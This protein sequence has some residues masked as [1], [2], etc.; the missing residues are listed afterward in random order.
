MGVAR[1]R[2]S[3]L[4]R[5]AALLLERE[6]G[7]TFEVPVDKMDAQIMVIIT[8]VCVCVCVRVRGR[9]VITYIF[10]W[11]FKYTDP[12]LEFVYSSPPTRLINASR[13]LIGRI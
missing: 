10:Y 3:G 13:P 12:K 6:R 7:L 8:E 5:D 2:R 4:G 11:L 9:T 1:P